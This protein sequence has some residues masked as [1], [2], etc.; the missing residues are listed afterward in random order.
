MV[1]TIPGY[2]FDKFV[3]RMLGQFKQL[4]FFVKS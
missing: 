1:S 3:E 2:S 4:Y